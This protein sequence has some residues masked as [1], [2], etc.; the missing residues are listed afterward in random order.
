MILKLNFYF[1]ENLYIFQ[2]V[3]LADVRPD[4]GEQALVEIEQEFGLNKAIFVKTDV[5]DYI[6]YEGE[7]IRSNRF[8]KNVY[9]VQ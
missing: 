3:T 4:L 6:E 5:T 7:I 9:V 2:A 8:C 1:W